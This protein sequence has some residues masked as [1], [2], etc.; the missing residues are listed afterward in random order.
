LYVYFW[1]L[2]SGK[3]SDAFFLGEDYGSTFAVLAFSADGKRLAAGCERLRLLD[4]EAKKVLCTLTMGKSPQ[5]GG[6]GELVT[7][8]A[9]APDARTL[10]TA[11]A[12]GFVR[13][14]DPAT[15][16]ERC[17]VGSLDWPAGLAFSPDSTH[18][19]AGTQDEILIWE[20]P[21]PEG[22]RPNLKV[23]EV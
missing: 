11:E 18:L 22:Q 14:R 20:V 15:G 9:F 12:D 2:D 10:A 1:E 4:L 16:R 21:P 8:A 3:L 17:A 7:A 23:K 5:P 6:A 13:L 19:V